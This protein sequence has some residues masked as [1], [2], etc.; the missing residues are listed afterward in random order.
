MDHILYFNLFS[1][2]S[3]PPA[4]S[5]AWPEQQARPVLRIVSFKFDQG[6]RRFSDIRNNKMLINWFQKQWF[7]PNTTVSSLRR[8]YAKPSARNQIYIRNRTATTNNH[9]NGPAWR[10]S[11]SFIFVS[12]PSAPIFPLFLFYYTF[13]FFHLLTICCFFCFVDI[14]FPYITAHSQ[15]SEQFHG[16]TSKKHTNLRKS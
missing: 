16:M 9:N 7:E 11:P 8:Q 5:S 4:P 13:S 15:D 12:P 1:A 14:S 10:A 6:S 2:S 3:S